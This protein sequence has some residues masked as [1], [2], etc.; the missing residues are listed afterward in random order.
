MTPA[1]LGAMVKVLNIDGVDRNG[2]LRT[3]IAHERLEVAHSL[4]AALGLG[5][6]GMRR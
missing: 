4:S 5:V 6:E 1:G 3:R 2:R